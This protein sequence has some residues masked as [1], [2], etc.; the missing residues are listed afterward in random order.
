VVFFT[1]GAW[2]IG[3]KMWGVLLARALS[4]CCCVVVLPDYRNYPCSVVPAAVDDV[5]AALEWTVHHI[6]EH[7]GDPEQIVV[8]GQ[9]AGGHLV[10]T[11][12]LRWA[13]RNC[14]WHNNNN[15]VRHVVEEAATSEYLAPHGTDDD[16]DDG[17][18]VPEDEENAQARLEATDFKGF[19]SL[20]A[21]YCLEAMEQTFLKHGLDAKL[22]DR[23]FGGER[24]AYNPYLIVQEWG[25][26]ANDD[27]ALADHLPPIRIYHGSCDKTVPAQGSIDFCDALRQAGVR[28]VQ[29]TL[30]EGWSHTDA[31]LEC[32][33]DADHGFH[34]DVHG[35]LQ[36][37]T[38]GA[39]APWPEDES[40]SIVLRRL[41]PH[42]LIQVARFLNPF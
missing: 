2:M 14:H 5:Q 13:S 8:V 33:L 42:V 32:P 29:F 28:D 21:P 7:G 19:I 34:R 40:S 22:V 6:R 37:W 10:T 35:A 41:C 36:E 24:D 18:S 31:I 23:I 27:C 20:S 38:G 9:S 25:R 26:T 15:N 39:A 30:Y 4:G 16:D 17:E 11:A 3:Y 12:L 1:G